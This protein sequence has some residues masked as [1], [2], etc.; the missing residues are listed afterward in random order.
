MNIVLKAEQFVFELFKDK[1]SDAYIYHNFQHT[2]RVFYAVKV[3]VENLGISESDAEVLYLAAWF[4]DTGYSVSEHDHELK[5]GEVAREFLAQENY[6]E[7]KIKEVVR[8]IKA[9]F[10]GHHPVDLL[11]EVIKDADTSHFADTNYLGISELLRAEWE[12]TQKQIYSDLEWNTLNRDLLLNKHRYYTHY[13]KENWQR[14]KDENI[15]ALQK[16]I[17]K[18]LSPESIAKE[19]KKEGKEDKREYS[20][21]IDTMFRVTL[22]NHT[23]LSDIADSKAN[24]LL[25]VNAII[26]SI[27]LSSLIPKLDAPRNHHLIIPTFILL[28]SSVVSIISAIL[29]TRP[30]VTSGSFTREEVQQ[31]KVNILF[32]GNF[33]KMPLPEYEWAMNELMNDRDGLYNTL[34]KDLYFLGLVLNKKYRLLRITYGIFMTGIILSVMAFV[35]AFVN[36]SLGNSIW[37]V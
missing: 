22:N 17:F 29:S 18:L 8:L 2:S 26:I 28:M 37:G 5:G 7:D 30:K 12:L 21:A 13:A 16:R 15:V 3:L 11:E 27:V 36:F 24:I 25:S 35:W 23:R 31:K 1:A 6:P 9:T 4:H 34:T 20:R 14:P 19:K 10:V 33:Y 32:F